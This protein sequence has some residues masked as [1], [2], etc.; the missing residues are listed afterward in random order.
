MT[1]SSLLAYGIKI[2]VISLQH[3]WGTIK[4]PYETYRHLAEG[5]NIS[6]A[7]PIFLLCL[8]YFGWTTLIHVGLKNHPLL[9]SFNFLKLTTVS[10]ATFGIV[11]YALFVVSHAFGGKGTIRNLFLPWAYSLLPTLI[12]FFATSLLWFL[13]PPPRTISLPGKSLSIVF[14]IFSSFLFFWKGVLYYLTLRFGMKLSFLR[15]IGVSA[16]IFPLG[17]LYSILMYK[18]GIFRIPFL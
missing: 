4:R 5:K 2:L 6:P 7:I 14:L 11:L 1:I 9:I 16:I 12:W 17:F 15:V 18:L 8:A 10:I 13:F 3:V